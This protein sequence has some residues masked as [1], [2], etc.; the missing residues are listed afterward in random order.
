MRL[1]KKAFTLTE[2]LIALGVIGVL[3]AILLP[4]IMNLIPDQNVLMAKRAYYAT[5]TIV[6]DMMNNEACYPDMTDAADES[7]RRIGFDDGFPRS[8][9]VGWNSEGDGENAAKKFSTLF[10]QG[11]DI[12]SSAIDNN[13]SAYAMTRDGMFYEISGVEEFETKGAVA[14]QAVFF[15]LTY[16]Y[17]NRVGADY[18]KLPLVLR[19]LLFSIRE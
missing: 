11:L 17:E 10:F 6:S 2:L 7:E 18:D 12:K 19:S 13:G 16:L 9:C 15:A 8:N 14:K 1:N 5:Q 4:V 3:T